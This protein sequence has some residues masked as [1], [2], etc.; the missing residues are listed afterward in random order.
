MGNASRRRDSSAWMH[1]QGVNAVGGTSPMSSCTVPGLEV[2]DEAEAWHNLGVDVMLDFHFS[3]WADS[4]LLAWGLGGNVFRG[5]QSGDDTRPLR[6]GSAGSPRSALAMVQLGQRNQSWHDVAP[7]GVGQRFWAAF[8]LL[9]AGADA[10]HEFLEC[11]GA[12]PCGGFAGG[13]LVLR[14]FGFCWLRARPVGR[15][16]IQLVVPPRPDCAVADHWQSFLI[17]EPARVPCGNGLR[18]DVRLGRLDRQLVV[19]RRRNAGICVQSLRG[20]AI[21]WQRWT[22]SLSALGPNVCAGWCYWAPDWVASEGETSTE[23]S[24]WENAAL[25]DF[26]WKALPAWEVFNTD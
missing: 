20:S 10:V 12:G 24:A 17:D 5:R 1:D 9:Q 25:F 6:L 4:P 13:A 3:T 15:Q 23:G 26:E 11:H 21:T 16:P 19:D 7:R 18:M 22:A 8:K 14:R 2:V